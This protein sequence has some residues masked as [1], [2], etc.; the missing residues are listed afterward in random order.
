MRREVARHHLVVHTIIRK[1]GIAER[2][3]YVLY[4]LEENADPQP[5][6]PLVDY[7]LEHGRTRSLGWQRE[8][9][10]ATGLF[11]DFLKVNAH[12][13]QSSL[14]RPQVLASFAEALIAGTIS[15]DGTDPSGLYW[16]SKTVSRAT[17]ILNALTA[18]SDWLVARYDTKAIN[19]W[20]KAT[21]AEQIA[22]WRRFEIRR[23]HALLMHTHDRADA[24]A[25][26]KL[27]RTVRVLRKTAIGSSAPVKYFPS[28]QIT[29]LL[30]KGF[31]VPGANRFS[32]LHYRLNIRDIMITILLHGGGLRESESFHLY[33]SD[34]AIDPANPKSALV[35]I[36]HPEQ[37]AAPRDFIDPLTQRHIDADREEYLQTKWGLEP[38]SLVIGRFHAGWKDLY[39]T[40]QRQKY[41]L[42]HWF[43]S[44]WGEVFLELFKLYITKV[45]SRHSHHPFLFV[46]QKGDV[47]G[48]PYTL[49]S[50]RQ[51]HAKAV[52]RIGLSV[53]K[54]YGTTPHGHRHAYGKLLADAKVDPALIQRCLHHKSIE[55][56]GVYTDPTPAT[57]AQILSEAAAKLGQETKRINIFGEL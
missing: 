3:A 9:V 19:P 37:G 47:A 24:D 2:R 21:V 28:D 36:F 32:P 45:R 40:D 50:F 15:A 12:H 42:V 39:L 10:R 5:M 1:L 31:V 8:V 27:A 11:I 54:E 34:V 43:P 56:Q 23:S 20:R 22:Y 49:A 55:S 35:K 26:A 14:D 17:D 48:D 29:A 13:F 33:V 57:V 7:V 52:K 16:Q 38:R 44:F 25:R 30:E 51:A 6:L 18:F 4:T 53:G 41:A 46:S